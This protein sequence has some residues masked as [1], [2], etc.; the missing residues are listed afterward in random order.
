MATRWI[1]LAT[2]FFIAPSVLAIYMRGYL[3]FPAIWTLAALC[4]VMLMR[5]PSFE[6]WRLANGAG[7]RRGLAPIVAVFAVSGACLTAAL[8]IYDSPRFLSLPRER[9]VLWAIIMVGYP[10]LSVY[11][12][13]IA[14]RAFFCHRYE[15]LMS[16]WVFVGVSAAAFGFAHI[17]MHN[18]V[19][20]LFSTVGGAL[21]M[22]TYQRTRS[23]L[24]CAFEHAIYGCFL[25]T[26]GWGSYFYGGAIGR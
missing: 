13:E 19:A 17:I 3:V 21:F 18:P 6:R 5:D 12:Q 14:F 20:V 26:I 2:L 1:E 25:F 11:P 24:A 9:P 7:F 16:R 23:L 8:L 15:R 22:L 10:I 4:L